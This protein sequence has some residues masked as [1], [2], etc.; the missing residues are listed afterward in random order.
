[1]I[2]NMKLNE[3]P[4]NNIKNGLK[5]VEL[6]LY[7]EKRKLIDL[8]DT[9]IFRKTTDLSQTVE[10]KVKG[11]LRYNNFEDLFKDIDYNITGPAKNLNEKLDNIHK[12]YP[13]EKENK[14]GIL[15]IHVELV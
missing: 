6:R 4:F 14:Y 5:R 12:I 2:H 11:L 13:V 7:D 3:K 1:M 8:N 15:A 10:V 9:I